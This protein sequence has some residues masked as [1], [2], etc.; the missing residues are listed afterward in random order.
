MCPSYMVTREE[1]HSTRGRA[2]LLFEML[3]GDPMRG[4]WHNQ[5]VKD[6][7]DLCLACKGCKGE[8][9]VNVDMATYKA[10]F[11]SHY[12]EGRRRP[13]AAYAFGLMYWW[14]RARVARAVAGQLRHADAR[15]A[16]RREVSRRH[17]A[18][19][20][21]SA[22]RTA[23]FQGVVRAAR[24]SETPAQTQVILWPDTWNNHFHPTTAQAAV[25]VLEEAGFQVIVP[26]VPLCCG[27]PLYDY[28]MLDLAKTHA[29]ADH[30]DA[31]PAYRR[32]HLRRGPR[33]ELRL[34]LSRRDAQ[35]A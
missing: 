8:C 17:G 25:E 15:P 18:A 35:P 3:E 9:P 31:A 7:L 30:R 27:R 28:G 29:A 24:P 6:A 34:G 4:G 33:A 14:A 19:A 16:R 32:R 1:K 10:E 22:L 11:L 23:D 2:R 20:P 21:H 12:Y 26:A 5:E 13:I